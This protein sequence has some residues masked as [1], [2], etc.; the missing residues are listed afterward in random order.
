LSV[1]F[2]LAMVILTAGVLF[3]LSLGLSSQVLSQAPLLIGLVAV[4]GLG[5]LARPRALVWGVNLI[6]KRMHREPVDFDLNSFQVAK[7][8]GLSFLMWI[9]LGGAFVAMAKSLWP[10]PASCAATLVGFYAGAWVAGLAAIVAPGGLG[11]REGVLTRFLS[12]CLGESGAVAVA[13]ASRVWITIAELLFAGA[14]VM[15]AWKQKR[16]D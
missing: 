16:T 15:L 12:G 2:E 1:A 9:C 11:V 7:L 6:L 13:L 10:V 14:A 5:V 8:L 4:V 3:L